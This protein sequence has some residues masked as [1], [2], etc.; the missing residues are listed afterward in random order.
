[1]ETWD[2]LRAYVQRQ[3]GATYEVA[4]DY[5]DEGRPDAADQHFAKARAF[6]EVLGAMARLEDEA[7]ADLAA[8][9]A[10]NDE[11]P[12]RPAD[13]APGSADDTQLRRLHG[14]FQRAGVAESCV[15]LEVTSGVI[16]RHI[17]KPAQMS[18]IEA[19]AILAY[20]NDR[21]TV[22]ALEG[23]FTPRTQRQ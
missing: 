9:R 22:P 23:C 10:E 11:G 20:L 13:H 14:L 16:G 5:V 17:Q 7:A 21:V 8:G 3:Y 4:T 15:M 2:S 18:R 19:D 6:N 12:A 1:M